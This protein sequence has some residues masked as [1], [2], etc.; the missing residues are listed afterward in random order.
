[1][2]VQDHHSMTDIVMGVALGT[3]SIGWIDKVIPSLIPW[4]IRLAAASI[5][6]QIAGR[7]FRGGIGEG[8]RLSAWGT[9]AAGIGSYLT[10][11][12]FSPQGLGQAMVP[13]NSRNQ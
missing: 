3:A 7:Y 12:D 10:G 11:S 9:L 8:M 13:T 1:M 6:A 4:Q 2:T 5:P